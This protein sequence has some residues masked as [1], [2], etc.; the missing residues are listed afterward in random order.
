GSR[1]TESPHM[2]T[3]RI[4]KIAEAILY[5]GY[6]LYPYRPSS[7]KNRQRWTFGGLSPQP[8]SEVQGGA[9]RWFSQ[10]E[11]LV[12]GTESAAVSV[13][14]RFLHLTARQAAEPAHTSGQ[15]E[16]IFANFSPVPALK[17]GDKLFQTWQEAIEREFTA[18][19]LMLSS[20]SGQPRRISFS[21]PG[22]DSVEMLRD[23]AGKLA[24]AF[25]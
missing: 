19:A 6:V 3:A 25:L 20:L 10:T 17:I 21:F 7:T 11:C 14:V 1:H 2:N 13:R 15:S 12:I 16:G 18:E 5:E 8:Y 9:E 24:G 23:S 4:D 22:S